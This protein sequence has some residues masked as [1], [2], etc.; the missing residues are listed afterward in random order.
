MST[1]P[2][3]QS[4]ANSRNAFTAGFLAWTFDAFDFFILTYVLSQVA[5]E[6]S[7]TN[8]GHRISSYG[9][10]DDAAGGERLFSGCWG[11]ITVRRKPLDCQY[12][13]L[14]GWVECLSGAGTDL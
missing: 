6:F 7:K 1:P 3:T 12:I 2:S 13:V 8:R 9:E 10:P 5:I 11:T 14:R 4:N